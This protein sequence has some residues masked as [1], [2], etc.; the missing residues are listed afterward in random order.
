MPRLAFVSHFLLL[1][2][3]L[4]GFAPPATFADEKAPAEAEWKSLF[5][6]KA[7]GGWKSVDFGGEGEV[8]VKEGAIQLPAGNDMTGI[9]WTKEFPKSNYELRWEATKVSGT[10]FFAAATFPV[11]EKHLTFVNGGWGGGLIGLSS[12]DGFDAS[13]NQTSGVFSFEKGKAYRFRVRVTPDR[14]GVWI[15]D[16][17]VIDENIE[18]KAIGL[19]WEMEACR[20]LGFASYA[21]HGA[22]KKIEYREIKAEAEKA[23]EK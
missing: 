2:T 17:Q 18:G 8:V 16:K 15:D 22:I 9:V 19:R 21:T 20:P 11:G 7:L 23:E 1:A 14:I 13:E 10:D 6:G 3:L 4:F 12:L 5:D